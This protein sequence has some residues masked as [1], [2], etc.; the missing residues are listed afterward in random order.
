MLWWVYLFPW[1]IYW[2]DMS[3]TLLW[4]T[5]QFYNCIKCIWGKKWQRVGL[6]LISFASV[7]VFLYLCVPLSLIN[8]LYSEG[9]WSF[10]R[11][12]TE[13][14]Q[15]IISVIWHLS[16]FESFIASGS[17][18]SLLL[19]KPSPSNVYWDEHFKFLLFPSI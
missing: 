3:L 4:W 16:Y 9:N 17:A 14:L 8:L 1:F 7:Y 13:L 12:I 5:L 19:P 10:L 6:L 2:Y 18:T 11:N 15:A